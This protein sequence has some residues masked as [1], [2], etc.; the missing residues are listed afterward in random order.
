LAGGVYGIG[1]APIAAER[2]QVSHDVV[3]TDRVPHGRMGKRVAGKT[4]NHAGVVDGVGVT[5]TGA[6]ANDGERRGRINGKA[7]VGPEEG[8]GFIFNPHDGAR[9][10]DAIRLPSKSPL[11]H[12]GRVGRSVRKPGRRGVIVPVIAVA[13]DGSARVDAER[14]AVEAPQLD[15]VVG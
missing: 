8:C 2:A 7:I 6:I 1:G 3:S 5:R 13:H 14:I 11:K 4:D 15:G 12:I 9:G 10:I